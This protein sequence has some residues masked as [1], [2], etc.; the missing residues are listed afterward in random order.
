MFTDKAGIKQLI[1]TLVKKGLREVVLSPGSRNAPL[2]LSF[3]HHK[4]IQLT[5][6]P[7]ERSA[8]YF[9]LG[10]AQ[11]LRR[12]VAV[13]C[14]SGTAALNYAPAIAEAYYQKIPLL[15]LT[16][17]R[18]VAWVDQ[19]DGQT[20]RQRDIFVNYVKHGYEIP[21]EGNSEE[22]LWFIRRIASQAWDQTLLPGEGPV[23]IN[24]PLSEP[25]YG[26]SAEMPSVKP[27]ETY[28]P[29][30]KLSESQLQELAA[31]WNQYDRKLILSG[32]VEPN[33]KLNT[34]LE[35][36]AEDE[37]VSVLTETTGNFHSE[38]FNPC[39]DRIISSLPE[40]LNQVLQP[41]LLIT[42]GGPVISKRV[43]VF[44]RKN[45]PLEHWHIDTSELHLD[46][47]QCL[48]HNIP[49]SPLSFFSQIKPHL[50][51]KQSDYRKQWKEMDLLTEERHQAFM[52][53]CPFS[54]LSAFESIL[55]HIPE[56][57][58]LQMSN[59]SPVRYVQLFK[60][61]KKL[62]YHSNRGASGIDGCTSTAAG[63]AY[64]S[65]KKTTLI[66][67][68]IGFFYDSNGLWNKYL[69]KQLRIVVIN[70]G[71]GG[72]FRIIEGPEHNDEIET[73]FET[74]QNMHAE[75]LCKAYGLNYFKASNKQELEESLQSFYG[76]KNR[77]ASVLEIF[78]E[79][80]LNPKIL[81]DYF[82]YLKQGK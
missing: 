5:V 47:Y 52:K 80:Q 67:G 6:I 39:I 25:L 57:S 24:I 10:M 50:K 27:I 79:S 78:T 58:D 35:E 49:L 70:N 41:Q 68:D 3:Y 33:E 42:F 53:N 45:S 46:T 61:G 21:G 2:S 12:P 65:G 11:Q 72:I 29:E 81:K 44:I 62:S 20:I 7:D 13:V 31:R 34:L 55:K 37:S 1:E 28:I 64:A 30:Q 63:A 66:T 38:K 56:N 36:I 8:G 23:H 43:K 17:D 69:S 15:V 54:D 71:G 19:A 74:R 59:S 9:A 22:E 14:T 4:D 18:P 32:L 76:E 16:A 73:L 60:A 40:E 48:T 51:T 26:R 75:F 82:K 77:E